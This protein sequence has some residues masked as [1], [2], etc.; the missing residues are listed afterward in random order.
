MVQLTELAFA[1]MA[2]I[3]LG[4]A[5]LLHPQLWLI[6]GVT[7]IMAALDAL[8]RPSLDALVPRLVDRDELIAASAVSSLRST[9]AMIVGP[10]LGGVLIATVGL[11][12]TYGVDV[13]TFAVSLIA[14]WMM[15]AVP[16]PADAEKVSLRRIVEGLHYACS[17]PELMGTYLVDMVAMFFG[18]P[19]A[20]FPAL[21]TRFG[22]PGV[23]GLLYAAPAVGSFIATATSGWS[24][25]VHRHGLAV[26]LAAGAWGLAIIGFG[27]SPWLP[28]ALV[29]LA[30]AGAADMISGLFRSTIWNQTIPDSLRGRLAGIELVSYSSGPAL[31][32]F[33]SGVMAS[34]FNVRVSVVSGGVLCVIGTALLA[35]ALP[36]F[37][38]YDNRSHN[39]DVTLE[40]RI[41]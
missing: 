40:A 19:M 24:N 4:N 13:A 25:H 6:Y 41:G 12:A 38:R 16:P 33:E 39:S 9:F 20:L 22:G 15:R 29:F 36:A 34:I 23:L 5:L 10:A 2:A 26:T 32:D 28:L 27:L 18:M 31:G 11:P 7:V 3:L 21:A 14:L 30:G 8:Q 35:F 1:V 17:R 37:I